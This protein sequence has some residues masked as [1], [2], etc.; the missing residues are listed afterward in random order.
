[1]YSGQ[2]WVFDLII[3]VPVW[4]MGYF[5]NSIRVRINDDPVEATHPE[6]AGRNDNYENVELQAVY[7]ATHRSGTYTW[8]NGNVYR[9]DFFEDKR[10]G[11]VRVVDE[12]L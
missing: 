2:T 5:G 11:K 10:Q 6:F 8:K 12:W 4:E 3:I 9:G 1:M 7:D